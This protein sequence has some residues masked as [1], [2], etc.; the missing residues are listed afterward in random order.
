MRRSSTKRSSM[1]PLT[2][3]FR[4]TAPSAQL[5]RATTSGVPPV[6]GD[7]LDR[8]VELGRARVRRSASTN[9]LTASGAPLRI[10]WPSRSTPLIRVVAV[11]GMNSAST[12]GERALADPVLL[13][14]DDD[15]PPL[16]RL[17]GQRGELGDVRE[18]ALVDAVGRDELGSPAGCRA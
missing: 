16:G 12:L 10:C 2:M 5:S 11:K 13:G 1:P 8:V 7:A 4:C 9:A 6:L 18:L 3:S 14:Q 17:V 15:R